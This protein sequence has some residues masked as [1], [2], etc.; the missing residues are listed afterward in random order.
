MNQSILFIYMLYSTGLR[1]NK[2]T[3]LLLNNGIEY[4]AVFLDLNGGSHYVKALKFG[5]GDLSA[6]DSAVASILMQEMR[7]L[8]Q[9]RVDRI[10]RRS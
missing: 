2:F 5:C 6:M 4:T 10:I 3:Y 9:H 1:F 8:Y 7:R